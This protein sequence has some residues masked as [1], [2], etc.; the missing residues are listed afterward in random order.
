VFV[1]GFYINMHHHLK[2]IHTY[3]HLP[4][5]RGSVGTC[6]PVVLNIKLLKVSDFSEIELVAYGPV[7]DLLELM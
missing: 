4:V 5:H 3:L 1:V 7:L 6:V 2:F